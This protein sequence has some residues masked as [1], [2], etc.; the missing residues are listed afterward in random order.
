MTLS[1]TQLYAIDFLLVHE[2]LSLRAWYKADGLEF[3]P[4]FYTFDDDDRLT[5][6]QE[7]IGN[8]SGK[9][10]SFA[11]LPRE[12]AVTIENLE[13][14]KT[15]NSSLSTEQA[16]LEFIRIYIL[17]NSNWHDPDF[18]TVDSWQKMKLQRAAQ[19]LTMTDGRTFH[20]KQLP[21][22]EFDFIGFAQN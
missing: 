3:S 22:G 21:K 5:F 15:V 1:L 18:I 19:T 4:R 12:F 17:S 9:M 13:D 7:G 10:R 14:F 2:K 6:W 11:K 20:L 8:A 16:A